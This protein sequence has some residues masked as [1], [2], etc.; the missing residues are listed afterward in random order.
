MVAIREPT[1]IAARA[2]W[3]LGEVNTHALCIWELLSLVEG[4]KGER[5]RDLNSTKEAGCPVISGQCGRTPELGQKW[6]GP[7]N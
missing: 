7:A 6:A 2:G 4:R 1:H 5:R 3:E